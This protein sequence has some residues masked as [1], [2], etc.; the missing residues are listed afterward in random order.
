MCKPEDNL[1]SSPENWKSSPENY[2][3]SILEQTIQTLMQRDVEHGAAVSVFSLIASLWQ[4][5]IDNLGERPLATSDVAIMMILFKIAR[6]RYNPL[7]VDN[8]VDMCGYAALAADL[9]TESGAEVWKP[10]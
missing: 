6:Q 9:A 1:K 2:E 10:V 5:I 3:F 8:Y 7:I 4:P